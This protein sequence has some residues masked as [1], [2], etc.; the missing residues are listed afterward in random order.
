MKKTSK[1]HLVLVTTVLT[2]CNRMLMPDGSDTG[3]TPGPP[4]PGPTI[5]VIPDTALT[6]G[7]VYDPNRSGPD[8]YDPN[9]NGPDG[10]DPNRY[11]PRCQIDSAYRD[12][13]QFE[14]DLYYQPQPYNYSNRL[15]TVF[16]L[17]NL[18]DRA[19][20][21]RNRVFVVRGGFGKASASTAS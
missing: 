10:Y 11:D 15:S 13:L 6:A 20:Y 5:T 7:P 3:Y 9:R 2:S 4:P 1:I 12:N 16:S 17:K 8:G 18:H 19:L 14:L 21:W